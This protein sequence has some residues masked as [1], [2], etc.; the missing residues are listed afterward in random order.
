MESPFQHIGTIVL[1]Y[2]DGSVYLGN[3]EHAD[4]V[5][6]LLSLRFLR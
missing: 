2:E 1:Y 4:T 5:V 6:G 3:S